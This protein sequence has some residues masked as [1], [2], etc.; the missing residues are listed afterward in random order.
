M[1]TPSHQQQPISLNTSSS[2]NGQQQVIALQLATLQ[3]KKGH[4]VVPLLQPIPQG[5]QPPKRGRFASWTGFSGKTLWDWLQL[6]AVLAVPLAVAFGTTYFAYQQTQLSDVQHQHEVDAAN[7]QHQRDVD[8]ANLQHQETILKSYQ[9]DLKDL[10]LNQGLITSKPN[11]EVRVIARTE[12][13]SALRQ[14]D[15]AR[16]RVFLQFLQ[17][18]H[19]IGAVFSDEEKGIVQRYH[20]VISF[21]GAD[22]TSDTLKSSNL[23]GANL[24]ETNLSGANLSFADLNGADLNGADLNGADLNG[25]NLNGATL[26]GA[27][28]SGGRLRGANLS[29]GRLRGANLSGA[30]LRFADFSGATLLGANLSGAFLSGANLSGVDLTDANLT[31]ADLTDANLRG[32]TMPDGSKHP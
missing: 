9:D 5:V 4:A 30:F 17:D 3:S 2:S 25:A 7:L 26:N 22:L 18:A 24:S 16:N 12:V 8:A 28:L 27:N 32:A 13:L 29:G 15:S 20:N 31:D 21:N 1:T 14:L 19:L 10:M 11:D 6:L 23:S